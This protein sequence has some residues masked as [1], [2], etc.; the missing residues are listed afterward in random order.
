MT[1]TPHPDKIIRSGDWCLICGK[2][3]PDY[4]P[5]MCCS[6][7]DC[8][9]KGQPI[10]PCVCSQECSD[11]LFKGIGKTFEERR[12]DAGI[13]KQNPARNDFEYGVKSMARNCLPA[14]ALIDAGRWTTSDARRWLNA[15]ISD[16][17]NYAREV[18]PKILKKGKEKL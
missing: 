8:G 7:I 14:I 13:T 3:V 1:P 17:P 5:K 18:A 11:A 4:V 10:D 6:G 9:C 16:D 15:V 12:I 2:F